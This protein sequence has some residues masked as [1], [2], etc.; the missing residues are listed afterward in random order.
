KTA[1]VG[2]GG[3][4]K[5]GSWQPVRLTLVAGSRGTRGHLE[6]VVSDGDRAPVVYANEQAAALDLAANEETSML[7]YAKAGPVE[8][9]IT[10]QLRGEEGI[11]WSYDVSRHL[12]P[13]LR[14]TQELIVGVGPSVGL[15]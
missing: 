15:E 13:A 9:H 4:F 6:L 1:S 10:V 7:L 8:A 14:S 2:F 11:E 12:S 3:K 5:A